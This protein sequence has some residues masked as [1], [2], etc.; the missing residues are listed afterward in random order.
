MIPVYLLATIAGVNRILYSFTKDNYWHFQVLFYLA[1]FGLSFLI[2]PTKGARF[3]PAR[4]LLEGASAGYTAG[5]F[6]FFFLPWL[7]SWNFHRVLQLHDLSIAFFLSPLI[8][9][10]WLVGLLMALVLIVD[11]LW[12]AKGKP[13][14][15]RAFE[16]VVH[17]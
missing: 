13:E 10:S 2:A 14:T 7:N 1:L 11:H 6:A 17:P 4:A 5:L 8:A 9:M 3:R 16:R 12:V 15:E